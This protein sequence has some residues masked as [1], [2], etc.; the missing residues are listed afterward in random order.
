MA[1]SPPALY[2][3]Y[4][5]LET[6][7]LCFTAPRRAPPDDD[8]PSSGWSTHPQITLGGGKMVTIELKERHTNLVAHR[9]TSTLPFWRVFNSLTDF[10][11]YSHRLTEG[12]PNAALSKA[13]RKWPRGSLTLCAWLIRQRL[14]VFQNARD[15]YL[16]VLS[17]CLS[18][19]TK[20]LKCFFMLW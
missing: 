14:I 12:I 1:A 5:L 3:S 19:K 20:V 18:V 6:T 9:Q 16:A 13:K 4:S 10:V 8:P 17:F 2:T 11:F 15:R 7:G